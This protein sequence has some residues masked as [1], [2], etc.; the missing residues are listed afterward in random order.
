M[1]MG[2]AIKK[3]ESDSNSDF[4]SKVE[5]DSEDREEN[6]EE[7]EDMPKLA[8]LAFDAWQPRFIWVEEEEDDR[9]EDRD[10]SGVGFRENDDYYEVEF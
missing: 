10:D 1:C 7:E 9:V 6:N 5:S 3:N 2:L 8:S 4:E